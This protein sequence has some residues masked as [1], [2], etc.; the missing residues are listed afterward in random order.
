M[1][2][3]DE[4]P[5]PVKA[6][7]IIA[8]LIGYSAISTCYAIPE[9]TRRV[10]AWGFVQRVKEAQEATKQA[11]EDSKKMAANVDCADKVNMG[12]CNATTEK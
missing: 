12:F 1:I 7:I 2:D 4:K 5:L 8:L 6:A 3:Q 10:A 11:T 9:V